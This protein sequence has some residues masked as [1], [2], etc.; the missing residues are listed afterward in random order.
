MD[1]KIYTVSELTRLVRGEIESRYADVWVEGEISNFRAIAVSGHAYFTLKDAGAQLKAVFFQARARGLRFS[2]KDGMKVLAHGRLSVYEPRGEYQ[3]VLERLEPQGL[4]A[5]QMALEEL[6]KKLGAEGLFAAERKRPVP[7]F[8]R[9]VAVITSPTGSVVHD[10]LNVSGR[11]C[12]WVDLLI[13]PV[14]VQGEGAAEEICAALDAA[15]DR[16]LGLDLVVLA[17]GGGSLE[18]L[19]AF[20]EEAVAR[21]IFESRLPV[22]SAVGHETDYCI[23]DFVA[24]L[25]AP[26]P[27]AAAEL[28]SISGEELKLELIHLGQRL[29]HALDGLL[30]E[31]RQELE[32][33]RLRLAQCDPRA[34]LEQNLQQLDEQAHRL[35]V[36]LQNLLSSASAALSGLAG[37]L[38]ALSP[39]AILARG[40]AAVYLLPGRTLVKKASQA[41]PGDALEVLLG[42]GRLQAKVEGVS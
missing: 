20:N 7:R 38:E 42:D 34:V 30:E 16:S 21:A 29:R 14:K 15:D 41:Q 13:L 23:A 24:D 35:N 17:R 8:P 18:D 26:T 10:I 39:L 25:R 22:I 31:R 28:L 19:W 33:W 1:K 6:K 4:G 36:A 3:I 37:R 11:R 40:Y 9:R 12:P 5:L 2:L 32:G 27:S